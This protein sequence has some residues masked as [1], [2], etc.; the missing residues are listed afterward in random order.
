MSD[1]SISDCSNSS[2]A[3]NVIPVVLAGGS[4]TRLWPLSR[5]S[6]PK[7]F[8]RLLS[9]QSL[10]QTTLSRTQN[11]IDQLPII[12]CN[13]SHRFTTAEQLRE[14]HFEH[15]GIL[16]EP[17]AKNTAPA[18]ALAAFH[19]LKKTTDPTLVVMPADHHIES[20]EIFRKAVNIA[21]HVAQQGKIVSLGA[22]ATKPHTG[23]G[24]I[25]KGLPI[26]PSGFEISEFIEKPNLTKAQSFIESTN[27]LWNCGIFVFNAQDF[28][29]ELKHYQP[30]VFESCLSA[31]EQASEDLDFIRVNQ[32]AFQRSPS[33]SIDYAVM[34]QTT[35]GAVIPLETHWS[36]IGDWNELWQASEKDNA[37]NVV[38]GDVIK[39][40]TTN[41]L[42]QSHHRLVTTVG[43]QDLV[44]IETSDSV[45]I[46]DRKSTQHIKALITGL[47]ENKRNELQAHS[48][49]YRPWGKYDVIDLGSGYQVKRITLNSGKRISLQKHHHRAEHWVVVS[50]TAKVTLEDKVFE[51]QKNES[52]F[53]PVGAIHCLEN[54]S[55][56]PLELIEI[57]S[58]DYLGEDDIMRFEG[59]LVN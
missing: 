46:A 43:V 15:Q 52:T 56:I 29:N 45:L 32:Q 51:V 21:C 31:Y 14:A 53:I 57:Q 54:T 25:K 12:V 37:G 3:S 26:N 48:E 19:A 2:C 47:I 39:H 40:D 23:Y 50:G 33:I 22:V 35:K 13:E 4:G 16:L 36:D 24:Y 38:Q 8:Q 1:F 10:L 7:Q 11:L 20:E 5:Q 42:I 30:N 9:S 49:V 44:V 27:Y 41:S 17:E 58:G 18:I 34:E 6:Y 59:D 28:L 55:K